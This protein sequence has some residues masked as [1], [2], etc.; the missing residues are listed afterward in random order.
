MHHSN[1]QPLMK[2]LG[3]T[4]RAHLRKALPRHDDDAA[5]VQAATAFDLDATYFNEPSCRNCGAE[6]ATK[7]CGACGQ[8]RARRFSSGHIRGE[9]WQNFRLFEMELVTA[10]WRVITGPGRVA[11]E[12]VLGA[13][14]K[15]MHPM[16]LLLVAVGLLLLMLSQSG[17][18]NTGNAQLGK[19]MQLVQSWGKWSFSLGILAI[20]GS[21]LSVF[22]RRMHYNLIEHLILAAYVQAVIIACNLV[23]LLPTLAWHSP[24]FLHAHKATAKYYMYLIE[25]GVVAIAF[26]QFFLVDLRREWWRLLLAAVVFVGLNWLLLRLYG[27]MVAKIVMA[28]L[29]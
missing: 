8:E 20:L 1:R 9:V 2:S 12:Y 5:G 3:T 14:K 16:K 24:E 18:L 28:Q 4:A 29:T 25:A 22:H 26:R 6:I 11:R 17:Y 21:S 13:R 19:A 15:Q 27:R 23:N 7:Y 10:A